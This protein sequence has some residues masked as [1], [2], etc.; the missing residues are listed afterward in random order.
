VDGRGVAGDNAG[1]VVLVVV[2][3]GVGSVI[4]KLWAAAS[5]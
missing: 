1:F 3:V 5:N 2:L 4:R